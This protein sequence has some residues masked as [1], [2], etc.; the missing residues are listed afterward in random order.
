[1]TFRK[2]ILQFCRFFSFCVKQQ[3]SV[4]PCK[5]EADISP[6]I[7]LWQSFWECICRECLSVVT[8]RFPAEIHSAVSV[9][10]EILHSKL[11]LS[12]PDLALFLPSTPESLADIYN[13]ALS[14]IDLPFN[15]Q[16]FEELIC[17]INVSES[18][19][20]GPSHGHD[21]PTRQLLQRPGNLSWMV[22]KTAIS[23][24]IDISD[25]EFGNTEPSHE[26]LCGK[27]H[28][29]ILKY[30]LAS[31]PYLWALINRGGNASMLIEKDYVNF[32][33]RLKRIYPT[34]QSYLNESLNADGPDLV[35]KQLFKGSQVVRNMA[36]MSR[37]E[38]GATFEFVGHLSKIR[39]IER[40]GVQ[41]VV[42]SLSTANWSAGNASGTLY[43]PSGISDVCL[44]LLVSKPKSLLDMLLG[45][46]NKLDRSINIKIENI[47]L[48]RKS[49]IDHQ[50]SEQIAVARAL[51]CTKYATLVK[52]RS[53]YI[54]I[55]MHA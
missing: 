30:S 19:Q 7:R 35:G 41:V 23:L 55:Y 27:E 16:S 47:E 53:Q 51:S 21:F 13:L 18:P 48:V 10:A 17:Q 28:A 40:K 43:T 4:V 20:L 46:E 33:D 12:T 32:I 22:A 14:L 52:L 26:N 9:D 50:H 24:L 15:F 36:D 11:L 54:S 34:L 49:R 45:L 38:V 1:M 39:R 8:S 31:L 44:N 5:L 29:R 3:G 37:L 25:V 42:C 6:T 2:K